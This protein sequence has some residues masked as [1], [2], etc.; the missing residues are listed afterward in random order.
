LGDKGTLLIEKG[1]EKLVSSISI[2]QKDSTGAGDAF[3][4]GV[5]YKLSSEEDINYE[6]FISFANVVG[7]ITCE[8]YGA[9]TAMPTMKET[10]DRIEVNV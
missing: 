3:V 5:L 10:L 2:K 8:N 1:V 4:G 9:I 7:A 6:S